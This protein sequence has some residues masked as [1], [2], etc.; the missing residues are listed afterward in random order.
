MAN[1]TDKKTEKKSAGKVQEPKLRI[2]GAE[3]IF[4]NLEDT[5]FG[6]SLTIKVTPEIEDKVSEFWKVNQ[7]GNAKTVIGEPN[8]K[9]YEQTK[10]LS[11]KVNDST[12]FAGVNGLNTDNL[13]FGSTVNFIVN[14]FEYNNKFTK[15][16]TYVGASLS[17]VVILTGK[18]T[19]AD[20]DLNELLNDV[21]DVPET[22]FKTAEELLGGEEKNDLPF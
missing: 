8:Y 7:I 20:A 3:V 15:G 12:K 5:G 14:A 10:Q 11:L 21:P 1:S 2:D 13:G 4:A 16:E 6:T 9:M 18:K 19:G 17:A 22:K